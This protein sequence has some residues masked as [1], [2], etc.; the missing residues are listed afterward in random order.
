MIQGD[1]KLYVDVNIGKAGGMERIIVYEGDS[2][3][4]LANEFCKKHG[5]NSEMR[6][7]L[8][9]LLEQQIAG[10]LP[11]II[12]GGEEEREEEDESHKTK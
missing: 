8:K 6:D 2:V 5:L 9:V 1:P 12:E 10:V 3:D 11:K 4:V 7:K